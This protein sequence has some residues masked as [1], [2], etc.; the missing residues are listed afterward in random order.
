MRVLIHDQSL[1]LHTSSPGRV[2]I[3]F[4]AIGLPLEYFSI[5]E[6]AKSPTFKTG[7]L[8][9]NISPPCA[10]SVALNKSLTVCSGVY[11]TSH[12]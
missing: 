7:I 6:S 2:P 3:I 4:F 9:T 8:R 11:K 12:I 5:I 10:I 1:I